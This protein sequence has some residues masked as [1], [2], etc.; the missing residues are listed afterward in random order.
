MIIEPT[1][2]ELSKGKY[3]RFTLV[4]AAA[5]GARMVTDDYIAQHD[6]AEEIVARKETDKPI[7]ML[8]DPRCRDEK[9]VK[10]AIDRLLSEE[11]VIK[12]APQLDGTIATEKQ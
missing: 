7:F 8:I 3:N 6:R 5:K 9:A 10:V 4:I 2:N 1:I 11:Y 12:N